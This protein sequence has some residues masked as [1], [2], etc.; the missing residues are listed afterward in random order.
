MQTQANPKGVKI[1]FKEEQ[2]SPVFR[3]HVTD[4]MRLQQIMM[5]LISNAIKFSDPNSPINVNLKVLGG[6]NESDTLLITVRDY[7]IGM[8][9][10][11]V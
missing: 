5:N 9:P 7:G 4:E 6:D 2:E 3:Q 8:T 11:E 10:K 1:T